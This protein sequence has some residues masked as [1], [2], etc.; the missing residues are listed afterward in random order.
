MRGHETGAGLWFGLPGGRI[1]QEEDRRAGGD[2]E[3]L[4]KTG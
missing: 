3:I 2:R 1:E 4:R